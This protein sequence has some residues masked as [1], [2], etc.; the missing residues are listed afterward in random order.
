MRT[1]IKNGHILDPVS[2]VNEVMDLL[3]EDGKIQKMEHAII[4]EADQIIDATGKYVMPGFI[5]LHVHLRD[6]G[7][8]YKETLETGVRAAAHG[9]FTTIC[10][11]PNTMPV[12]DCEEVVSYLVD[13]A[14]KMDLIH[15]LPI[16][17]VTIGQEGKEL[18]DFEAMKKAG[19]CAISEDGKSVM[20]T[21]LYMEAMKKAAKLGLPVFAHCEDR[22]LVRGGV[23]NAGKKAEELGLKGITNTVED[24]ITARD[25]FMAKEAGCK[26]HLCHCSTK[27]SVRLVKMGKEMGVSVSAEVC[28]HHFAMTEDEI[29][30]NHGDFKMNPPLRK[31][32][33][34][35]ALIAGLADGTMEMIATDHAPHG[36]EEN[37]QTMDKAP[38]G[39]V[40]LETAFSLTMTKLVKTGRLTPMQMVERMSTAPAR[41][42]GLNKGGLQP[43]MD[44]DIVIAD[45]SKETVID[46]TTFLSKG[47]NTP[48]D[49][50]PVTGEVTMTICN[51]K[52]VYSK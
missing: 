20:S 8:E 2:N 42:L 33:D 37:D 49:Q 25:I 26:L 24:V 10:A 48:F 44:A 40:G 22:P 34:V 45:F 39:I 23:M 6:P 43:G 13:K 18:A 15:V 16:G 14:K 32:E 27:D 50:M 51:G 38:F 36:F 17:A 46:K 28:P 47:R 9:G 52:V 30:K 31:K 5:D 11:M 41:L 29:T 1:V 3:F 12:T 21:D 7:F 19:I 35:E 4:E